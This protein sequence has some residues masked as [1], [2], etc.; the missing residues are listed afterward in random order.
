MSSS[1]VL[2]A[3]D[4]PDDLFF[5]QRIFQQVGVRNPI[6]AVADG[7]E[8]IDYL[9][10][11]VE[12]DDIPCL[13]LLDIKMPRLSGFEV[14][15]WARAR[16]ALAGVR[17]VMLSGSNV[18]KDRDLASRLGAVGYLV[19]YATADQVAEL[20]RRHCPQLLPKAHRS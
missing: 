16:P 7:Q 1:P 20:L 3:E 8:A 4:S 19:K 17:F 11:C 9:A 10:R 13:A 6:V 2:I 15:E 18:Q 14:L 5:A 12:T